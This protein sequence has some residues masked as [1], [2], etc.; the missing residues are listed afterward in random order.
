MSI[1]TILIIEDEASLRSEVVDML[2]FEGYEM[3]E[4]EN[5]REGIQKA[6]EHVPD[7]ILCDIMMPEMD[8][9]GVLNQLR[10][11]PETMFTPFVFMTALAEGYAMVPISPPVWFPPICPVTTPAA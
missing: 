9:M 3:L 6:R 7:L 1:K 10:K 4:A 11:F 2:S 8:G 5:G